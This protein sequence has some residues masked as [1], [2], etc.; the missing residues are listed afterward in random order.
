V[1]HEELELIDVQLAR[2]DP[3]HVAASLSRQ[4]IVSEQLAQSVNVGVQRLGGAR[5]E[6][7]PPQRVDQLISGYDLVCVQQQHGQ[8]RPLLAPPE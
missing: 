6:S 2:P 1:G 3:E 7:F 4:S 5:R 8:Q